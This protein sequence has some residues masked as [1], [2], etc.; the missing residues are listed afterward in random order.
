MG[1]LYFV[2]EPL[3]DLVDGY[4][5]FNYSSAPYTIDIANLDSSGYSVFPLDS[6]F[7]QV[8]VTI[9]NVAIPFDDV[10]EKLMFTIWIDITTA[11]PNTGWTTYTVSSYVMNVSAVLDPETPFYIPLR[12][13]NEMGA[14]GAAGPAG[15]T[16]STG[17][18]AGP[19]GDQGPAGPTGPA[20]ADSTVAGP[21]GDVGPTGPAG[22]T[23]DQGPA[24][25]TGDAG[26]NST[27]PGPTGPVSTLG[28]TALRAS[29]SNQSI[30]NNSATAVA[31]ATV[32]IATTNSSDLTTNT[33]TGLIT[34]VST[35]YYQVTGRV[36]WT[37]TV[38]GGRYQLAL[39]VGGS[40]V[41]SI[42]SG[43]AVPGTSGVSP[44]DNGITISGIINVTSANTTVGLQVTQN[45][46]SS[47][48]LTNSGTSTS[49]LFV[50]RLA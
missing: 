34:C 50:N 25:P 43:V 7:S 14:T 9:N 27:V 32:D 49:Y 48:D 44:S 16:G 11:V 4:F 19:T 22:S 37:S 23:G 46:G 1:Y 3:T 29:G 42:S 18:S 20:G 10:E 33:S 15:P 26:A 35:G 38:P 6:T 8:G 12:W 40:A 5:R 36:N 21:T 31:L 45:S 28:I 47:Q 24:G 13:L 17:G 2:S 41:Q 39:L 30:S